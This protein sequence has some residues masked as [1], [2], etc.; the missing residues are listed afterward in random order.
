LD[1][2]VRALLVHLRDVLITILQQSL[3]DV[4]LVSIRAPL[5]NGGCNIR[6]LREYLLQQELLGQRECLNLLD[7]HKDELRFLVK[8]NVVITNERVGFHVDAKFILLLAQS[9]SHQIISDTNYSFLDKVH[10]AY[11]ILFVKDQPFFFGCLVFTGPETKTDIIKKFGVFVFLSVE[12]KSESVE[13][14]IE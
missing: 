4:F 5:L 1:R 14:I 8:A 6:I 3:P 12:E 7:D 10:L 2:L 11:L 13:Y 9:L